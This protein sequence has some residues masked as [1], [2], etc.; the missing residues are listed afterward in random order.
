MRTVCGKTFLV[1]IGK[2]HMNAL[3]NLNDT[4]AFLWEAM[5]DEEFEVDDLVKR[6]T[7]EYEV[8]EATAK[9]NIENL[10]A[11]MRKAG[12]ILTTN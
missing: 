4:A 2:E 7:D 6:L 10:L 3:I 8:S 1:A 11:E 9:E 5:G 12:L